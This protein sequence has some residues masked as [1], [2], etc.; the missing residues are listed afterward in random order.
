MILPMSKI[1]II[2]R[3]SDYSKVISTLHSLGCVEIEDIKKEIVVGDPTIRPL[4]PDEESKISK[5]KIEEILMK[6]N[7][8]LSF[9]VKKEKTPKP[10]EEKVSELWELRNED[11]I[12]R[13]EKLIGRIDEQT[14]ELTQKL[15]SL[16]SEL[17]L[18]KNFEVVVSKVEPLVRHFSGVKGYETVA[19][20][21]EKK[22][23]VVIDILYDEIKK[24]TGD[25]FEIATAEVDDKTVAALIF[26]PKEFSAP[27][28]NLL[29]EEN[30][31]E[32]KLPKDFA[33]MPFEEA[34]KRIRSRLKELPEKISKLRRELDEQSKEWVDDLIS[35][36]HVLENRLQEFQVFD[37]VGQTEFAFVII[38]WTPKKYL[39]LIQRSLI[40]QFNNKVIV[41]ELELSEEEREHAPIC[42]EN[43]AWAKA[44][45]MVLRMWSLP[46]Y[47]TFDPSP[48]MAF[49]YSL[50]FGMIL[51]DVGYGLILLLASFLIIRKFREKP[52]IQAL[53]FMF[54]SASIMVILFGFLYGEFFG[55]LGLE[56]HLVRHFSFKI[57]SEEIRLPIERDKPEFIL[58]LLIMCLSIG[59]TQ[60]ILGQILGIIIGLKERSLKHILEKIGM[61]LLFA[62]IAFFALSKTLP[63]I[64]GPVSFLALIASVALI[65]YGGGVI[66]VVHIFSTMGKIFSYLRIMALGLAGVILAIAANKIG[67]TLG[68]IWIG[69]AIATLFH[70]INLVV[71]SF[72]STIHSLR[73]NLIEWFDQFYKPGGKPFKPFKKIGG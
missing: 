70:L 65:A 45:E 64:F 31:S 9:V 39:D 55:N 13:I 49:F 63:N 47:G 42:M 66:G 57:G 32:I 14:R 11:L 16:E 10:N 41:N 62:S 29:W 21:V 36:K 33:E 17:S 27:V 20:L 58:P 18:L 53:G 68:N 73:L 22:H 19:L 8:I 59:V 54:L 23:R 4:E 40:K 72:S 52:G 48:M 26:Y 37:M 2:G 46:R 44:Y 6:V 24:I 61:I 1:E 35:A 56:L 69:I 12:R 71:H 3:R 43:P 38:G 67:S 25:K 7:S 60:I 15:T 5:Q 30:V 34:V 50:F 51:G 28:H